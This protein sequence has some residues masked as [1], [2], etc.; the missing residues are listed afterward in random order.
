MPSLFSLSPHWKVGGSRVGFLSL[1]H[2]YAGLA[3]SPYPSS[4]CFQSSLISSVQTLT[5]HFQ[6][7]KV[8]VSS[9]IR[10]EEKTTYF[11][12]RCCQ[13]PSTEEITRVSGSEAGQFK[14]GV[15]AHTCLGLCACLSVCMWNTVNPEIPK[16]RAFA[17]T[18]FALIIN[19]H[20][21]EAF[22]FL[23]VSEFWETYSQITSWV[24]NVHLSKP[25]KLLIPE[26]CFLGSW[27]W[28]EVYFL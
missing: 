5:T 19:I 1:N 21:T 9:G 28:M 26:F 23:T 14:Y 25:L 18:W 16:W 6:R 8:P 15:H 24:E 13:H 11:N 22:L 12:Q 2:S 10:K 4:G 20:T 17:P 7:S 27:H 3:L